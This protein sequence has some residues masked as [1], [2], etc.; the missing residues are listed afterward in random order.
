MKRTPLRPRSKKRQAVYR[1]RRKLVA[2]ML[3]RYPWCARC[4][5]NRSV[6]LH[7]L[8][9]RSQGG[10]FLDPEQIVTVCRECHD[11]ITTHPAEAHAGGW[12]YWSHEDITKPEQSA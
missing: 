11:W 8:K 2:E 10:D 12:T 6:D 5:W 9:N 4:L 7:E 3:E 1:Q